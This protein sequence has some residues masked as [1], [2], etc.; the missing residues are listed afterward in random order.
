MNLFLALMILKNLSAII[1]FSNE[2][3]VFAGYTKIIED[4]LLFKSSS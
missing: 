2:Y 3:E 1:T 4:G